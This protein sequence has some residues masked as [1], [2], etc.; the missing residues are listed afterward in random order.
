MPSFCSIILV[1]LEEDGR[2]LKHWSSQ[3]AIATDDAAI[4]T[5]VKS[6]AFEV[7][8]SMDKGSGAKSFENFQLYIDGVEKF[9][10]YKDRRIEQ[11]FVDAETYL[12]KAVEDNPQ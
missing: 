9:R 12:S 5:F 3:E 2:I 4:Q 8:W 1:R 7:M 6:G 11:D 10:W